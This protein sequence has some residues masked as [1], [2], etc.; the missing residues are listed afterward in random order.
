MLRDAMLR[1]SRI[2]CAAGAIALC[3]PAAASAHAP[4]ERL[5]RVIVDDRGRELRLV[6][7]YTDGLIGY[8]PVKLVVRDPDKRTIA[9]TD[10]GRMIS[11]VCTRPTVCVVFVYGEFSPLPAQI[12]RL[13]N[14]QLEATPSSA[15]ATLGIVVPLWSD[16]W[17]YV[18]STGFL[19]LPWPVLA[20]L[21]KAGNAPLPEASM[22]FF[23]RVVRYGAIASGFVAVAFYYYSCAWFL[24]LLVELSP[25]LA[26]VSALIIGGAI[27]FSLRSGRT[28]IAAA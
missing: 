17:G 1:A 4:Y 24:A 8:D 28:A 21:W 16:A 23:Q 15:L 25:L 22:P 3:A 11:V 13:A 7:S 27:A 26:I 19:L 18:G 20:A 9:E 12:W 10:W 5:E 14:G 2:V 6:L